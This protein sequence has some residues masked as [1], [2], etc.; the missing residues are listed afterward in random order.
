ML[1]HVERAL[2]DR[3]EWVAG[4][5]VI[6]HERQHDAITT[7][8]HTKVIR[9]ADA[10]PSFSNEMDPSFSRALRYDHRFHSFPSCCRQHGR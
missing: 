9:S 3:E 8:I 7:E 1:R 6:V 5:D 10:K 2:G 4:R